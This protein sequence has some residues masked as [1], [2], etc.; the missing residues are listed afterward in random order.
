MADAA[1]EKALSKVRE[2]HEELLGAPAPQLEDDDLAP[3]PNGFDARALALDEV[4]RLEGLARA[5][6]CAPTAAAFVPATDCYAVRDG[7]LLTIDLPGL[8]PDDVEVIA[9][10]NEVIVR[11]VRRSTSD[12]HGLRPIAV[13]R[14]FGPFERR[15]PIPTGMG[16]EQIRAHY[17][18]GVLELRFG[19]S[20]SERAGEIDVEIA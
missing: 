13:E 9:S 14:A 1:L 3:I 4:E 5:Q 10:T 12:E 16:P 7:F 11:G 19:P 18:A 20:T 2:L 17:V 8:T 15:F 6:R